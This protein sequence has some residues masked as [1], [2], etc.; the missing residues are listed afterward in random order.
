MHFLKKIFKKPSLGVVVAH[1][2]ETSMYNMEWEAL[3]QIKTEV[4]DSCLTVDCKVTAKPMFDDIDPVTIAFEYFFLLPFDKKYN[5]ANGV[6]K[7]FNTF[8]E[9]FG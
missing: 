4:K 9:A 6:A 3:S 5:P 1:L 2:D 8:P 7:N